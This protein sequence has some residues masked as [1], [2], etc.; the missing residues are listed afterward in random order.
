MMAH[1]LSSVQPFEGAANKTAAIIIK[2]GRETE[3]PVNYTVWTRKKGI[4]KIPTDISLK[5][6]MLSLHR[7]KLL[8]E[9]IGSNTGSWQTVSKG[10]RNLKHLEGINSYKAYLGV[11]A[12]PYGVFWISVKELRSDGLIIISNLPEKGK[13]KIDKIDDVIEPD[14]IYPAIRG[15]DIQRW[16]A[17]PN[18][19]VLL[20][21]DPKKRE[22]FPES[23]MKQKWPRTYGYLTKF[24]QAFE[25][26]ASKVVKALAN[27]TAFYAVLGVGEYTLAN[28]KV[29]WKGMASDIIAAVVSETK[30]PFG[31]K[32]IIS[33]HTTSL[34][35]TSDKDEAHYLCAII[36]SKPVR[37][38]IK[39][40]SS[41]GRGFGT[42][43]VMN[44]VGIPRFDPKN[45][46][47]QQLT[48]LSQ[49][50]HDLKENNRLDEIG[51]LEKEV[52][53]RVNAL[54]GISD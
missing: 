42:P 20:S 21:Q 13:T 40:Y 26:Q 24:K 46:I 29:I 2:K 41:A 30:T 28:Y 23:V 9:P 48:Q 50:L 15:S 25:A 5:K 37:E 6:A 12:V 16:R 52:D 32:K 47:H 38:F 51:P 33:T 39:S 3:Y 27:R 43:S 49:G 19:F 31:Y 34:F 8:A 53:R 14:L 22:P 35:A 45:E 54:F 10:Q 18:I 17:I 1:D 7:N 11:R 44:H 4:G 36:N